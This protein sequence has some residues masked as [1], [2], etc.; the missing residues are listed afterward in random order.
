MRSNQICSF[1][2]VLPLFCLLFLV[3][4]CSP[5]GQTTTP[6][7]TAR[8]T[9]APSSSPGLSTVPVTCPATGRMSPIDIRRLTGRIAFSGGPGG[10]EDIYVMQADCSHLSQL[11]T[12]AGPEFDPSWSRDGKRLV[13]RDSRR[14]VNHDDEIYMM[15]ADGT[16]QHNLTRNPSDDWGPAWSPDF[17]KIAFNSARNGLPRIYVMNPDTSGLHRLTTI[18]GEYPAWSPDGKRIAFESQQPGAS[19]NNPNYDIYVM[20][21]DGSNLKQLTSYAGQDEGAAWSPDGT[22]IAFYSARDD[23]GQSGDIGPFFDIWVMNADGS[24]QTRLTHGFGLWVM[25]ADGSGLT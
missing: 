10:I 12:N 19:G 9:T 11:T 14:G 15:N 1:G 16:G 18:E 23:T 24:R 21:A 7:P 6:T 25:H 5:S 17:T 20:N 8:A 2:G 13:Y 4:A 3:V 22:R